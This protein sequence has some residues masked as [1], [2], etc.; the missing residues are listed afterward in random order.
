M[1]TRDERITDIINRRYPDIVKLRTTHGEGN[2]LSYRAL[3]GRR[4]SHAW[5]RLSMTNIVEHPR[6]HSPSRTD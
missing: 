6:R 3:H 4:R 2:G 1:P 5:R